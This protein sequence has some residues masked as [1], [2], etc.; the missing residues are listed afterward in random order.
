MADAIL[1]L[2]GV[3]KR[4]AGVVALDGVSFVVERGTITSL[5]GPNGSG[6]STLIDCISGFQLHD[7]GRWWVGG[8]ELSGRPPWDIVRAG[9]SRTFQTVRVYGP[10]TVRE[11]LAL[12]MHAHRVPAWHTNLLATGFM[13]RFAAKA[14][15]RAAEIG[16]RIGLD[17]MLDSPAATLSYGQQKL[18][19][20]GCALIATPQLI[21][22]DEPLAGVNPTLC[23]QI[24]ELLSSLRAEGLT[25]LLVEHN[26]DF[27]MRM[28]DR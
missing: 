13:R 1:R 20:L 3:S 6:K 21:V 4:Y 12:A 10:L 19:A 22:L 23:L 2:E 15:Q 11:N 9:M 17:R 7:G 27:V 16:Q 8:A 28:S 26:M 18:V 14:Q 25:T 5:I 24:G